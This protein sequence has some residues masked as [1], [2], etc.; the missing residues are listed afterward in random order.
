M[1]CFGY[2]IE[3]HFKVIKKFLEEHNIKIYGENELFDLSTN[4]YKIILKVYT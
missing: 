1:I 4:D 3:V 2:L